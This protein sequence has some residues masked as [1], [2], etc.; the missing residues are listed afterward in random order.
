MCDGDLYVVPPLY[1]F[2]T[3]HQINESTGMIGYPDR[4][5]YNRLLQNFVANIANPCSWRVRTQLDGSIKVNDRI[6]ITCP[7]LEV[8]QV[9]ARAIAIVHEGDSYGALWRTT[10]E[11]TQVEGS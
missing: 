4:L 5:G 2:Q 7:A 11:G 8:A 10:V 1:T 6:I 3:S 9:P